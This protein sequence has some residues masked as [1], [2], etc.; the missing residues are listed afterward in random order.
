MVTASKEFIKRVFELANNEFCKVGWTKRKSGF[1]ADLSEDI[2]GVIG[3]NKAI[4]RGN[5]ILEINPIVGV[6]SHK[7]EKMVMELLG[8]KFQPYAGAAIGRNVGYLT[9]EKKYKPW[10]FREEDD[11]KTLLAGMVATIQKYGRPFIQEHMELSA[12]CEAMRHS[13]FGGP[14]DQYR[15]PAAYMLLGNKIEAEAFL[16]TKLNEMSSRNDLDAESFRRFAAKLRDPFRH[17]A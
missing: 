14:H 12:L 6:G 17:Q 7:L 9:P 2:Y 13:K 16:E 8:Q 10:L 11:C 5:G 15:I 3:L 4:G 1:S